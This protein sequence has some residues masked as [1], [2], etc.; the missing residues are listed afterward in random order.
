MSD[1]QQALLDALKR[2]TRQTLLR[3]PEP[4]GNQPRTVPR[5]PYAD[6]MPLGMIDRP[7]TGPPFG[8]TQSNEFVNHGYHLETLLPGQGGSAVADYRRTGKHLGKFDTP[9]HA[10]AFAKALDSLR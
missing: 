3:S 4:S 10:D 5:V 2:A 6:V 8:D 9:D 7:N 1:G